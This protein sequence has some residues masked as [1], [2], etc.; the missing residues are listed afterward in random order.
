MTSPGETSI[1]PAEIIAGVCVQPLSDEPWRHDKEALRTASQQLRRE[2]DIARSILEGDG[3]RTNPNDWEEARM[4]SLVLEADG[5]A[6]G[7][8]LQHKFYL[9]ESLMGDI[10]RATAEL[11]RELSRT[12]LLR[13]ALANNDG[14]VTLDFRGDVINAINASFY[15]SSIAFL[16]ETRPAPLFAG[17]RPL[18]Y[19]IGA[20]LTDKSHTIGRPLKIK[21]LGSGGATAHWQDAAE[22]ALSQG[23]SSMDLT[24]TDFSEPPIS[25][26]EGSAALTLD[27]ERYS[28]FEA[29]PELP[30]SERFDAVIG[31]YCLDSVWQPEDIHVVWAGGQAYQQVYRVK[32]PDAHPR[33]NE[34]L[35]ALRSGQPL[36]NPEPTDYD[37]LFIETALEPLDLSQHPYGKYIERLKGK[38]ASHQFPGGLIK[39][40]VEAFDNQLGEDGVFVS[41]DT[42]DAG[43]GEWRGSDAGIPCHISGAA[44]RYKIENYWLAKQILEEVHGLH[45]ELL[46]YPQLLTDYLSADQIVSYDQEHL[47]VLYNK[48]QGNG[49]LIARRFESYVRERSRRLGGVVTGMLRP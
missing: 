14:A 19:V 25:D 15:A 6:G 9:T 39:K 8:G 46:R 1:F 43:I 45:V 23:A 22:G 30:A 28:L 5:N 26:T 36:A 27:S 17:N 32:V 47:D 7:P 21:E 49:I 37:A 34:L 40:V 24:L 13:L 10:E 31:E 33:R 38:V 11:G 20:L 41:A 42:M 3:L 44:G 48:C 29:F 4:A 16:P 35:E 12:E 2:V 18:N